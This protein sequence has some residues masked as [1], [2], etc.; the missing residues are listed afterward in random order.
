MAIGRSVRPVVLVS[1]E[2]AR[3]RELTRKSDKTKYGT[4]IVLAQDNGAQ[5][6]V[7]VYESAS[8]Y[9]LPQIGDFFVAE[10]T[11]EESRDYGASLSFESSGVDLLDRIHAALSTSGK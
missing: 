3:I 8:L 7:T 10:C 11:V 2:V 6:G 5:I 9:A 4:E 1:G